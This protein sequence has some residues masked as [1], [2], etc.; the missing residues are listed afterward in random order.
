[1]N[2]CKGVILL[3]KNREKEV[4]CIESSS[5]KPG[6][7][8]KDHGTAHTESGAGRN[9]YEGDERDHLRYRCKDLS[10]GTPDDSLRQKPGV[11]PKAFR[12]ITSKA[13][14]HTAGLFW[15][16]PLISILV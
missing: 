6:G 13:L 5:I 4:E 11:L 10:E 3:P 12:S 7:G 14:D 9:Y 2:F 8:L 16:T 1:M 15:T